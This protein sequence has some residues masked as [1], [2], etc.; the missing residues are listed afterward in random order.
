[1][2][3]HSQLHR[4]ALSSTSPPAVSQI[5]TSMSA[6]SSSKLS[7]RSPSGKTTPT[8]G[9]SSALGT[10]SASPSSPRAPT[11]RNSGLSRSK[12]K[13]EVPSPRSINPA[14]ALS[15][16]TMTRRRQTA[17]G[18]KLAPPHYKHSFCGGPSVNENIFL[19]LKPSA[20]NSAVPLSRKAWDLEVPLPISSDAIGGGDGGGGKWYGPSGER[21]Q[22][23]VTVDVWKKDGW[24]YFFHVSELYGHDPEAKPRDRALQLEKQEG[25]PTKKAPGLLK[26]E[27]GTKA[28]D[29][30]VVREVSIEELERLGTK[31]LNF[32]MKANPLWVVEMVVTRFEREGEDGKNEVR[33]VW[34]RRVVID[35]SGK[36]HGEDTW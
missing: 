25:P 35:M 2:M 7:S 22:V 3:S 29:R 11:S 17:V 9:P 16:R 1:M 26:R 32:G 13:R 12:S 34:D 27:G 18:I 8:R 23:R 24:G 4:R 15:E 5:S 19:E 31:V 14:V 30:H 36:S 28:W 20:G 33:V 21:A 6:Y 10:S